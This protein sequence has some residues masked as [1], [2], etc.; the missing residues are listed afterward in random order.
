MHKVKGKRVLV[1][2]AVVSSM[3]LAVAE[4][5]PGTA[6]DSVSASVSNTRFLLGPPKAAGPVVVRARFELHDILKIDDSEESFGFSGVRTLTWTDPRQAFDPT[7]EGVEEKVYQGAY[8]F[9]E[10]A[11]GWYPQ[12][13]LVNAA[14]MYE[15]NGVTLRVRADG[16][17]TLI[18]TITATAKADFDMH[19]FP[20]DGHRLEAVFEVAGFDRDE[21]V[22]EVESVYASSV[23]GNNVQVPQWIITGS[24]MSTRD[25]AASYAGRGGISSA[26]VASID[27]ER[28]PYYMFRLVVAPLVVI[29]LLSFSVFWMDRSSLGDRTS[30]S[31]IGI[32]TGV[33]YQM[34]IS[35]KMPDIAYMTLMHGFL[36]ISF[37]TMCATVVVNLVVGALDRKGRAQFGDRIDRRCRWIFPL[38][39]FGINLCFVGVAVMFY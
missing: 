23:R 27:V 4:P 34:M 12:L 25:R 31:F 20:L 28:D 36:N 15:T 33:T 30:V 32:L 21:V 5:V 6:I 35:D 1:L 10:V 39:Y 26:F 16:S 38:A 2:L 22:M 18:E 37:V 7:V 9:N 19:R 13:V 8:Q 11:T 29:V 14:G 24:G 3:A 17:S